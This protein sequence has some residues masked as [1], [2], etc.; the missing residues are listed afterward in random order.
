VANKLFEKTKPI[1]GKG[2][3]KKAK[4]KM[5]V[6]PELLR[7]GNLKKQ[8]QSLKGQNG[9]NSYMKGY[10]GKITAFVARKNKANSK[11]ILVSPQIFWGL[12][13]LFEKTKPICRPLDESLGVS[14]KAGNFLYIK[15]EACVYLFIFI[16]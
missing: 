2:K 15:K 11:P 16:V 8:S 12:K 14:N 7:I 13:S 9:V 5:R 4:V 3:S 1:L 10:Y 6:N